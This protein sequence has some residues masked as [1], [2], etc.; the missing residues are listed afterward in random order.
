ML[1]FVSVRKRIPSSTMAV[2]LSVACLLV[3]WCSYNS[4]CLLLNYRRASSLSVPIVVVPI[5][6]DN[7]F[8]IALQTSLSSLFRHV[9]FGS[10]SFIRYCRLG[11]EFHDRY[12][13]HQRL[14]DTWIL[15]TPNRNWFHTSQADAAYDI[16]SRSREFTRPVWM[17]SKVTLDENRSI[18]SPS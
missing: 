3:V 12:K 1:A 4:Y 17:M 7:P 9:P 6:P 13:T 10:F 8:W 5:S 2:I 18:L 14:G 16:L 11:W 15:V